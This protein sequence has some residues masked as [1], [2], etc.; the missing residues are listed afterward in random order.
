MAAA[1]AYS[2]T[3]RTSPQGAPAPATGQK[4]LLGEG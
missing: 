4:K 3:I 1:G 2:D